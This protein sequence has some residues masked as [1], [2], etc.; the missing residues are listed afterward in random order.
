MIRDDIKA[1]IEE[2]LAGLSHDPSSQAVGVRPDV[3]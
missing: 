2:L 3:G 1:R